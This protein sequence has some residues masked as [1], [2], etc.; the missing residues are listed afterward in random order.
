MTIARLPVRDP[1]TIAR[2][3][4]GVFDT[5]FPHLAQG[6]VASFNRRSMRLANCS[7]ISEELVATSKLQHAMLFEIAVAVAEQLLYEGAID[8]DQSLSTAIGRQRAHFDAQPPAALSDADRGVSLAVAENLVSILRHIQSENFGT[9]LVR[10]P[11]IPGYQWIASG[12][13]DFAVGTSLIE[14][15]CTNKRF[16]SADYRQ[17]LMYWLLSYCAAI[18]S[19]APEWSKAILV[20][21]RLNLLLTLSFDE[22]IGIVGGGRSKLELV[23]LF[24]AILGDRE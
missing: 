23:E 21:P 20:N 3:I 24:S 16:S 22:I 13:G 15:K 14:V 2:D 9:A 10:A 7:P 11:R 17:V 6:V 19:G 18:E 4:P 8:W 12:V 5:L 1:R